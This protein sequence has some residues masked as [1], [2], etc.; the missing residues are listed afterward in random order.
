MWEYTSEIEV[1]L[2]EDDDLEISC[3]FDLLSFWLFIHL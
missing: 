2:Y 1:R 3:T